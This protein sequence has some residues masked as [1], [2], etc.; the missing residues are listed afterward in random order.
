VNLVP[1]NTLTTNAP[2]PT[3]DVVPGGSH[4]LHEIVSP[5]H[6]GLPEA[7][8]E[9]QD[10]LL[11][12]ALGIRARLEPQV[13]RRRKL[14]RR[15]L[16]I[17]LI[18]VFCC[19]FS[20]CF[21]LI[22]QQL[23]E[24]LRLWGFLAMLPI[25]G[26]EIACIAMLLRP[27]MDVWGLPKSEIQAILDV[28]NKRA[29]P[30]LLD[31]RRLTGAKVAM[32]RQVTDALTRLLP[33]LQASDASLLTAEHRH[34]LNK[35]LALC[36]PRFSALFIHDCDFIVAILKALQQIGDHASLSHVEL[37]ARTSRDP[38]IREAA[39]VCLP[40]LKQRATLQGQTLL[41]PSSRPEPNAGLL[42]RPAGNGVASEQDQ[43]LRA[44]LSEQTRQ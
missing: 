20:L 24:Y 13:Q 25:F 3:L 39:E 37:L 17:L 6:T 36:G 23:P 29:I 19:A 10:A 7:E 18:Q 21:I 4:L 9:I 26:L 16:F 27:L 32:A 8:T 42:L 30:L 28:E 38:R 43:L 35:V 12:S 14:D 15:F 40:F 44:D 2:E 34:Q 5:I 1:I 22:E 41:H 31:V 33:T 11:A